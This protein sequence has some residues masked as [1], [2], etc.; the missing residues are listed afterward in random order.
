MKLRLKPASRLLTASL[1]SSRLPSL[2]GSP[3]SQGCILSFS[4][5]S[6]PTFLSTVL[7]FRKLILSFSIWDAQSLPS[8]LSACL[9]RGRSRS[10]W[11]IRPVLFKGITH[12]LSLLLLLLNHFSRVRLCATPETAAHE[13]SP[14]LGFS[15]QEHWS[16]LPFPSP[17]LSLGA[18]RLLEGWSCHIILK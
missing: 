12:I 9:W 1:G 16:G 6:F 18:H 4:F 2:Q 8:T 11:R 5:Y 10:H 13:A 15:R 14:S 3:A 17:I 7:L